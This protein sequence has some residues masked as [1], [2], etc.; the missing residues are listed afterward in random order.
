[1]IKM[2]DFSV[3]EFHLIRKVC[4]DDFFSINMLKNI[5]PVPFR[6]FYQVEFFSDLGVF[7]G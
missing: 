7:W 2:V 4:G 3:N 5:D 1:M 6:F